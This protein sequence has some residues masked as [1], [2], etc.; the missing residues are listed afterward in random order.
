M[1]IVSQQRQRGR[2]R[3]QPEAGNPRRTLSRRTD[4]SVHR[5]RRSF[6][7]TRVTRVG[8]TN[9]R[10]SPTM[11]TPEIIGIDHIYLAVS[12]LDRSEKFYDVLMSALG[13]WKKRFAI[14]GDP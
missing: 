10:N 1:L 5:L 7:P 8:L 14:D 4:E 9:P 6:R 13:F 3:E 12:D 11:S 2:R